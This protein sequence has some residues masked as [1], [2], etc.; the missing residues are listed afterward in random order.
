MQRTSPSAEPEMRHALWG[1]ARR[2]SP[3]NRLCIGLK[4][5]VGPLD[6]VRPAPAQTPVSTGIGQSAGHWWQHPAA[7]PVI[8]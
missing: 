4:E 1:M 2:A 7:A 8:S 5:P 3:C 6:N